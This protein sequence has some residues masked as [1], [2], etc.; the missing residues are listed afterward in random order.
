M[1]CTFANLAVKREDVIKQVYTKTFKDHLDVWH[2][3]KTIAQKL[4]P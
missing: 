4:Q 3:N 1:C 2:F